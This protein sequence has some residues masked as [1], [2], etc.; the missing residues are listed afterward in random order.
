MTLIVDAIAAAIAP[1]SITHR[2]WPSF[3]AKAAPL[4][5][6]SPYLRVLTRALV[7]I[8]DE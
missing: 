2:D 8:L 6:Q 1:A 5:P 7:K 3:G 4:Q